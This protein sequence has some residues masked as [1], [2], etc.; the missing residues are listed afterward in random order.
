MS[1]QEPLDLSFDLIFGEAIYKIPMKCVIELLVMDATRWKTRTYRVTSEVSDAA[2]D[3]FWCW[4]LLERARPIP[5]SYM[6]ACAVLAAEFGIASLTPEHV[7]HKG[8]CAEACLFDEISE[9]F[10]PAFAQ[11]DDRM[12]KLERILNSRAS[13]ALE[14]ASAAQTTHSQDLDQPFN[15]PRQ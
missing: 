6:P 9:Q 1:T 7:W 3:A 10:A 15:S 14:S 5:K 13:L 4:L 8:Q 11:L 12:D 2:F